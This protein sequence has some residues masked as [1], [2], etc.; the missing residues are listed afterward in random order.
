MKNETILNVWK[1][2]DL[3]AAQC[4]HLGP[5]PEQ[6]IMSVFG[7]SDTHHILAHI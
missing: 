4:Q 3:K 1:L 7:A 2:R 5:L 6:A